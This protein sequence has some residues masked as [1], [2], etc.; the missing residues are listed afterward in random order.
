MKQVRHE[1]TLCA[2]AEDGNGALLTIDIVETNFRNAS[3]FTRRWLQSPDIT[4]IQACRPARGIASLRG[5]IRRVRHG[6]P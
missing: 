4:H 5:K 2:Y 6:T 1:I 3:Y